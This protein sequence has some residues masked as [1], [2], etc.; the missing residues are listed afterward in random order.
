MDLT[1][2]FT[3]I[4]IIIYIII[5][6]VLKLKGAFKEEKVSLW[7]PFLMWRTQKGKNLIEKLASKKRFWRAYGSVSIGICFFTM[8][9]LMFVL[10]WTATLVPSI[11]KESAPPPQLLIGIPGLNPIIPLWYGII[12]LAVAIVMHEF[13]H[14][15]LTRVAELKVKSL[16][17]I[18]CIVPIGAFVEPDEEELKATTKKK[19]M[20]L[21]SVGPATNI[22]FAL[23]CALIFSWILIPSLSPVHEGVLTAGAYP[24]SPAH[25]SGL[26]KW[27]MEIV[28]INGTQ[29]TELED[30][31][32][33]TAPDPL[34]NVTV[35]YYYK[36]EL[37][38]VDVISGVVITH[39][40]EDYPAD[41]AGIEAGMI[42]Y[43]VN[44]TIIRND[45]DFKEAMK[46]TKA[47]Q[48]INITLYQY[49]ETG[50]IYF[51]FNTSATLEDKYEYYEEHYSASVNDESYKG[52]G[53]LGVGHSYLGL[54]P[55]GNPKLL[56]VRLSHPVSSAEN[57]EGAF[58]N[59][60]IY[61]L[62][63]FQRISPFS[64]P[65]TDI[66]EINGPLSILPPDLFWFITNVVYWLFWLSLMLGLTNA[67]PAVPLD[68][69]HI[70]KDGLDFIV[71]KIRKQL[72]PKVR[73]RYVR[74][75]S[76]SIA[77]FVLFLFLWQLVGPRI[78]GY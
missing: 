37:H 56:V 75:I 17:I 38:T 3:L 54:Y 35:S 57:S 21:F 69:G 1:L 18:A 5:L 48:T 60:A 19:R 20:R 32:K 2:A 71:S 45:D 30:F 41:K 67:L 72:D 9:L 62:L 68:G 13:A 22:I 15:I 8:I 65:M 50:K 31:E 51:T 58:Y 70:F 43:Q 14:G 33:V 73:E 77:L 29:I 44:G 59:V 27:W 25:E 39:V 11:P 64:S 6:A 24:D 74:A 7:G 47:G 36:G 16:G 55:G 12:A 34:Q 76:Y 10:I 40:S 78:L 61:I 23:I 53:F 63:P 28:E 66:Y 52:M 4:V 42:F 26:N 49:N 46:L